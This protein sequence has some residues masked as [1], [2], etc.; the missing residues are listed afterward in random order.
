M[1]AG[2]GARLSDIERLSPRRRQRRVDEDQE[3][4]TIRHGKRM[5]GCATDVA[6]AD[7]CDG[8]HEE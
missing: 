3:A 6:G 8:V 4:D 5:R 1:K 7:D 2:D